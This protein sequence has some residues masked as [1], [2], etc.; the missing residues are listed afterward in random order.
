MNSGSNLYSFW[1]TVNGFFRIFEA[2]EAFDV[3]PF[4][5]Y[6]GISDSELGIEGM[7][8]YNLI[9]VVEPGA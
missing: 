1:Y 9:E 4:Y 3:P 2:L 5:L 7:C 8:L 6:T